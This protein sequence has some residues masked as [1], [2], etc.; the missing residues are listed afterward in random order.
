MLAML[1]MTSVMGS[2]P[3]VLVDQVGYRPECAKVAILRSSRGSEAVVRRSDGSVAL[4]AIVGPAIEDPDSG[5]TVR[6]IDFSALRTPG[7]YTVEVAGVGSSDPFEVGDH[8]FRPV[9]RVAMRSFYAQR[10]GMS[11]SLAPDYPE[12]HYSACHTELGHY[13]VS[14]GKEGR[15]DVYG[16]WHDAGDYGKYVVN[17][18][19]TTGTL[20]YAY[21]LN[22][23]KLRRFDLSI[24]E[25]GKALPDFLAEIK[26]NLDWMLKMQDEDGGVW[27]KAT[28]ATFPGYIMPQDDKGN[29]LVIGSG[30]A[31]YKTTHATANLAAVAAIGARVYRPFDA[32]YADRC[33]RA[34][35]AAWE[36][37]ERTPDTGAFRNPP[38]IATGGYGE[39]DA[40][41][42]RLWAS[43]ELYRT[44]GEE[45]YQKDVIDR[46]AMWTPLIDPRNAQGWA[47]VRNMGWYAY[48]LSDWPS[49]DTEL[50]KRIKVDAIL[51]A[52]AIAAR[53]DVNGYLTP[54]PGDQYVWGS[55]SVVAN[56]GIMVW[57]ANRFR[58]K[59]LYRDT[60]MNALHYLLGRNPYGVSFVTRVG[61]R[62]AMR[63][64]HRPS[65]ADGIDEPWPGFLVGGSNAS[66]RTPPAKQ[67][68]DEQDSYTQNE[69][70][71]NWNAALVFLLVE[72]S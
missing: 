59:A 65:A 62:Y 57:M 68:V 11:V 24:P 13:H 34:A 60:A 6:H 53:T 16:G 22:S 21:E 51:A 25:S 52:D 63:P 3:E 39:P 67:W 71:I 19:I 26:W 27:H 28:T 36:W 54:L 72:A 9:L 64:H 7:R 69:N 29:Y 56:Y 14:S 42:E 44:T 49:I 40:R 23:D 15:R 20:L 61:A 4:S 48:A 12:F 45:R 38:G 41:D 66:R 35:V 18:G 31:P 70:A 5:D 50:V 55:N 8:V 17:S 43:A 10:C 30:A 32:K 37:L 46:A 47:D 58:P 1:A 2:V 33:L